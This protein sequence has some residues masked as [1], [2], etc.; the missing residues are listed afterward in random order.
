MSRLRTA[1]LLPGLAVSAA[2]LS[3]QPAPDSAAVPEPGSE[4]RVWLITMAPGDAV[5]ERF[6]HTALRVLD[7]STGTDVAYNW[8]I[9]DFDQPG[10]VLRFLK[11]QMLYMMA[12]FRTEPLVTAY[13][14]VGRQ[15]VLQ[16]VALTPTQPVALRD[17]AEWNAL[18]E[19][20]Q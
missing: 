1:A 16:E 2:S 7:S 6:G 9:F 8:G 3:A 15:V 20:R 19:H 17:Y 5:W 11:G 18:P 10:F 4:L 13:A 14:R 12:G